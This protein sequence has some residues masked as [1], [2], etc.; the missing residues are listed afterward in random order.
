MFCG[1]HLLKNLICESC[2][3]TTI[4]VYNP[5]CIVCQK[6]SIAGQTHLQ[7]YKKY[8]PNKLIVP[9]VYSGITKLCIINSKFKSRAFSLL[10]DLT[11]YCLIYKEQFDLHLVN[12]SFL[13]TFVPS[14]SV[15]YKKR[16]FTS[17]QI[18]A[19]TL[20]KELNC[21]CKCILKKSKIIEPFEH[22]NRLQ[23]FKSIKNGFTFC[24]K[25]IPQNVLLVDDVITTGATLLEASKTLKKAGVKN[26]WCFALCFKPFSNIY[27]TN[28]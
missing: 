25:S 17:S 19:S 15:R 27:Y 14:D 5:F 26:V 6:E 24:G 3:N 4:F 18:I 12:K 20:A 21:S 22:K 16:G 28:A 8:Y 7:C 9:F 13:I 11:K 23:R 2:L 1:K 10:S